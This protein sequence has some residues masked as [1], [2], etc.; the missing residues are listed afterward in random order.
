MRDTTGDEVVLADQDEVLIDV[1]KLP[2]T[3]LLAVGDTVLAGALRRVL[4]EL[5]SPMDVSAGFSS[6]QR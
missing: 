1:T 5:D 2:L 3:E 4:R 6:Y